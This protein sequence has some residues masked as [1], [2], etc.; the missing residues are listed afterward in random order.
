V[1]L[2]RNECITHHVIT[3]IGI[4]V[5]NHGIMVQVSVTARLTDAGV[6]STVNN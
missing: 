6:F 4:H 5:K 3:D 2:S 1:A